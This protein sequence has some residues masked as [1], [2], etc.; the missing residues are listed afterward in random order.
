MFPNFLNRIQRDIRSNVADIL[1]TRVTL[2]DSPLTYAWQGA[3][4]LCNVNEKGENVSLNDCLFHKYAVSRKEYL[5][6]GLSYCNSK[7]A[8]VQLPTFSAV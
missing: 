6:K 8:Q 7:M 1:N 5:D 3:R 4:L 2:A